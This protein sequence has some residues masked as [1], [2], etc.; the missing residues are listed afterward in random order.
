MSKSRV[1]ITCEGEKVI[2]LDKQK[3]HS[4]KIEPV[5]GSEPRLPVCEV[6]HSMVSHSTVLGDGN[7]M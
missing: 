1:N 2:E 7:S 4:R 3:S 5:L 6:G